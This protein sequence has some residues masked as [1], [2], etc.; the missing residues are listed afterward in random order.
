M[1]C[2]S[3]YELGLVGQGWRTREREEGEKC[4]R[5]R[6]ID[7]GGGENEKEKKVIAIKIERVGDT[8][9]YIHDS[10]RT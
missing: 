7:K 10:V 2:E 9:G 5:L 1:K 3:R 6:L 8:H 4:V